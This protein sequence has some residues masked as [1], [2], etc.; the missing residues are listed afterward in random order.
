MKSYVISEVRY[1]AAILVITMADGSKAH[2]G[3]TS[4]VL[5]PTGS[6]VVLLTEEEH[7]ELWDAALAFQ[8]GTLPP[9][10]LSGA[11]LEEDES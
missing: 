3:D 11:L 2:L 6:P 10:Y 8:A 7:D 5:V 1:D 9:E 4:G